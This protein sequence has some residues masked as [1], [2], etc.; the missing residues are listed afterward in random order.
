MPK[1]GRNKRRPRIL[2]ITLARGGSKSVPRKNILPING[3]PL[4]GYTIAE[5]QRSTYITRYII[6]TDDAEITRVAKRLGAEVPFTRPAH[7][8]TDTATSADALIHAV[9]FIEQAE[10]KKYD[11]I[12]ELMCT[13]PMKTAEDIDA[14]IEKLIVTGADSV[15]GVVQLEEYHPARVKK[16]VNDRLVDFAVPETSSRRQDLKPP[17]YLRNG[18]IYAMKRNVLMVDGFRYGTR[19]SR[20]YIMPWEKSVNVD[21]PIDFMIAREL[22]K[23]YPRPYIRAGKKPKRHAGK[24][25]R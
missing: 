18:A 24:K 10:G 1:K 7:L 9:D 14:I 15:I 5:A 2:A 16:I 13:N 4:I 8:A 17:A 23:K 6:S 12:V 3:V 20:P 19:N 22:I 25:R 21:S 11:Y